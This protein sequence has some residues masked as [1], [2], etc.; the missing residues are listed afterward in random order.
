[1]K[2]K[3]EFDNGDV[4]EVEVSEE[5]G[6]VIIDSRRKEESLARKERRHCYSLD[7]IAYEGKEYGTEDYMEMFDDSDEL[8]ARVHKAL[9]HLTEV[10]KRRL[11]ML[12]SGM[13]V[14]DIA[15]KENKDYSVIRESVMSAK[16]KFK[17]YF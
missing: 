15:R 4:T 9:S 10:Q 11:L 7:A 17:K 16:K 6:A 3:Y 14:M 2:V 12:A 5:V 8:N 1:M 13:T